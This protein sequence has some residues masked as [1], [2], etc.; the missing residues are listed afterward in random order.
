MAGSGAPRASSYAVAPSEKTSARSNPTN[1]APGIPGESIAIADGPGPEPE[2]EPEPGPGPEAV[3]VG[4]SAGG[5]SGVH[6]PQHGEEGVREKR[7]ALAERASRRL[8]LVFVRR[9]SVCVSAERDGEVGVGR[10]AS[11]EFAS[12]PVEIQSAERVSRAG[13]VAGL[14][15]RVVGEG[16]AAPRV[17]SAAKPDGLV[18]RVG[19][20]FGGGA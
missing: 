9:V 11:R 19:F 20:G 6:F 2:P 14:R 8:R 10:E 5:E 4:G 13:S 12:D 1:P 3:G 17:A 7:H 16:P 18:G 15:V